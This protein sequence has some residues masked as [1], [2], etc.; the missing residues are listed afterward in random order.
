M[1]N[2]DHWQ[3]QELPPWYWQ[4]AQLS[5]DCLNVEGEDFGTIIET[6]MKGGDIPVNCDG[7]RMGS[8][9]CLAM[10]LTVFMKGEGHVKF[11]Y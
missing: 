6:R 5:K 3:V 4:V 7:Q 2:Q 9:L 8:M 10:R 1:L 11:A